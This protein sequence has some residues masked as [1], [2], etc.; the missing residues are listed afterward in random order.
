MKK[1]RGKFIVLEGTDG[2]GK[3]TQ[4][5]L[6]REYL[7]KK[8]VPFEALDF[9]QYGQSSA[10][11]IEKYLNGGYGFKV[12]P[13]VASLFYAVDRFEVSYKVREWLQKGKLVLADRYVASNMGHQGAKI[14]NKRKQAEFIK[15]IYT[16]EYKIFGVPKPDLNIFL[17]VPPK[18]A[19]D[20]IG[21]K[22]ARAYLKG[23]KRDIHE[24]DRIHLKKAAEAYMHTTQ[25]FKKEF[26]VLHCAPHGRLLSIGEIHRMIVKLI[27]KYVKA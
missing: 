26:K 22:S 8:R 16:M 21:K 12:D 18:T 14:E 25:L 17:E 6:L 7:K 1:R 13:R 19:Y 15:W 27:Q 23:K 20:L 10:Y 9:P 4:F 11:F 2:S 3:G 24:R 5:R